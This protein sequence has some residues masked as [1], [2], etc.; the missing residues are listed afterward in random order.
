MDIISAL[1]NNLDV[2]VDPLKL[3]YIMGGGQQNLNDLL[4]K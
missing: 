1:T 3:G 4:S 2:G